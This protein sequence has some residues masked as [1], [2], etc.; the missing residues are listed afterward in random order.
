MTLNKNNTA[1]NATKEVRKNGLDKFYTIPSVVDKCV[2]SLLSLY[3]WNS[4]DLIVEPSAGNGM[5]YNKIPS[6]TKVGLDILPEHK[7]IIKQDFFTYIPEETFRN[8]LV[9]G[10]PPF[11]KNSSLAVKFFNHSAEWANVIAFIVPRTFRR[12]SIQNKLNLSFTLLLDEDIP[13]KPCSFDPPM[14]VKCCWQIWSRTQYDRN[15]IK[16]PVTHPHWE[17]LRM[18]PL[19]DNGQPTPPLNADFAIRAYGGKCGE[20]RK[21]GLQLLRPKSWHWIKSNIDIDV[22]TSNFSKLDYSN[23]M[24]TARQNSIGRAELVAL[25]MD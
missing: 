14:T 9:I 5:F 22:L 24:N 4:W 7:D 8:I 6:L 23:S 25:Y 12:I 19:D 3:K 13:L 10:N 17:F 15:V 1:M 2:L 11:G 20:I 16:L 18:G 21:E